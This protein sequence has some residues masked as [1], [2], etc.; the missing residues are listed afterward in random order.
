MNSSNPNSFISKLR[1]SLLH[2]LQQIPYILWYPIAA[3]INLLFSIISYFYHWLDDHFNELVARQNQLTR[4][5]RK[6]VRAVL[7]SHSN[8]MTTFWS[9]RVCRIFTLLLQI[10]SFLTTYAGFTFFLKNINPFAPVILA[11]VV[12]GTAYYLLNFR[13]SRKRDGNWKRNVLLCLVFAIS[14]TTSFVGVSNTIRSPIEDIKETYNGY[15]TVHNDY[16]ETRVSQKNTFTENDIRTA[17]DACVQVRSDATAALASLD[18]QTPGSTSNTTTSTGVTGYAPD[19]TP[20]VSSSTITT[21]D[22]DLELAKQQLEGLRQ[23]IN[24]AVNDLR[25]DPAMLDASAIDQACSADSRTVQQENTYQ[26]FLSCLQE[27][28]ALEQKLLALPARLA[29]IYQTNA[30]VPAA[31]ATID[32]DL[33][34]ADRLDEYHAAAENQS[35]AKLDEYETVIANATSASPSHAARSTVTRILSDLELLLVSP[36]LSQA[37]TIRTTLNQ[38]MA[39]QYNMLPPDGQTALQASFQAAQLPSSQLYP[40]FYLLQYSDPDWGSSLLSLILAASIDLLSLILSLTLIKRRDSVLYAKNHK[41]NVR[42]REEILEDCYT[43]LC[44]RQLTSGQ[45]EQAVRTAAEIRSFV[46]HTIEGTMYQF[47]QQVQNCYIP[48]S[49]DSFGYLTGYDVQKF[50]S[51][52][53]NL[54]QTFCLIHLIRPVTRAELVTLLK[55][56][57]PDPDDSQKSSLPDRCVDALPD[58]LLYLVDNRLLMWHNENF[59]E[60]LQA[61]LLSDDLQ[62]MAQTPVD[63]V[64]GRGGVVV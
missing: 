7:A 43:Y 14:I 49:L 40:F 46:S 2:H 47:I 8:I 42:N 63:Q 4:L 29:A 11:L 19:G 26:E 52:Q 21:I 38:V 18:A 32:S 57:F 16:L 6:A 59:S 12:Q 28:A 58:D 31:A 30:A 45:P 13:S 1:A 44:M 37:E 48:D 20:I 51:E 53:R 64:P 62:F 34:S 60:L 33:F 17:L 25:I 22:T 10:L 56:A 5:T 54:F 24:S 23:T 15:R 50:N 61:N 9:Y 39:D 27:H 55:A 41:E 3:V 36:E 35:A